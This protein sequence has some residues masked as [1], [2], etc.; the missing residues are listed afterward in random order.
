MFARPQNEPATGSRPS[1]WARLPISLRA[2]LSGLFLAILAL[3]VW[4]VLLV[5]LPL[6]LAASAE[7]A[8]LISSCGGRA[9]GA[10]TFDEI[11][12]RRIIPV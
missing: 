11:R 2:I 3:N 1:R 12:P 8:F 9:E 4:P 10:A 6:P 5:V 7:A